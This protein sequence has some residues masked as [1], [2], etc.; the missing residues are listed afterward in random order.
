MRAPQQVRLNLWWW[1]KFCLKLLQFA[2]LINS[3]LIIW[4]GKKYY[5]LLGKKCHWELSSAC[6]WAGSLIDTNLVL[7]HHFLFTTVQNL[8]ANVGLKDGNTHN[9]GFAGFTFAQWE[10]TVTVMSSIIFIPCHCDW[11]LW[12]NTK[13][14]NRFLKYQ[15]QTDCFYERLQREAERWGQGAFNKNNG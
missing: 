1:L 15:K 7:Q 2:F 6:D 4:L 9:T 10:E 3:V 5:L 14:F 8:T 12:C 13:K 11:K